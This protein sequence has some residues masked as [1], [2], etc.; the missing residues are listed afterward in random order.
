MQ[1]HDDSQFKENKPVE[2]GLEG[3][4]TEREGESGRKGSD[5]EAEVERLRRELEKEREWREE[6]GR[7]EEG[8]RHRLET[9]EGRIAQ[10]E[11]LLST[12]QTQLSAAASENTRLLQ[13]ND[14]LTVSLQ[15]TQSELNQL[16][17]SSD[18]LSTLHRELSL[19]RRSRL[20]DPPIS[21]SNESF[22]LAMRIRS[23]RIE[24][25]EE[26]FRA[27]NG[28]YEEMK[29]K[30]TAPRSFHRQKEQVPESTNQSFRAYSVRTT[31][32]KATPRFIRDK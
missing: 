9:Q 24:E 31:S 13:V 23:Q 3:K 25:L 20:P 7:R 8:L 19:Q 18:Y 17:D 14:S 16:K 30:I 4:K 26:L 29:A 10:L 5:L 2:G 28:K 21:D 6:M 32:L 27:S 22:S 11:A 1:R 12:H 15:H